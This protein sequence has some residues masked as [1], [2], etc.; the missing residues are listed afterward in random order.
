MYKDQQTQTA[1]SRS[2]LADQLTMTTVID[3]ELTNAQSQLDVFRKRV[4]K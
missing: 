3:N 2:N 1:S 4:Y